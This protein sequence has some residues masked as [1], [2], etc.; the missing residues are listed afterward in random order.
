MIFDILRYQ[1]YPSYKNGIIIESRLFYRKGSSS[2]CAHK[3]HFLNRQRFD[4]FFKTMPSRRKRPDFLNKLYCS[5]TLSKLSSKTRLLW[6]GYATCGRWLC[7]SRSQALGAY[8]THVSTDRATEKSTSL[9][10]A[11]LV[12]PPRMQIRGHTGPASDNT[13]DRTTSN[14]SL[15]Y[16][17][18]VWKLH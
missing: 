3:P 18:K 14:S 12:C 13:R 7:R 1:Q 5:W 17:R 8:G 11:N 9:A 15:R 10:A 4:T 16:P 2:R 6:L